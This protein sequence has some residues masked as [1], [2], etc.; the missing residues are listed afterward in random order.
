[1]GTG[2]IRIGKP[3][4]MTQD[5]YSMFFVTC[6]KTEYIFYHQKT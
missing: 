1:M 5:L 6:L 4:S 3:I 2:P